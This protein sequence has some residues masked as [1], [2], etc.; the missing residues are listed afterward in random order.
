MD[1]GTNMYSPGPPQRVWVSM[2]HLTI[3]CVPTHQ[4]CIVALELGHYVLTVLTLTEGTCRL[5]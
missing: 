1:T 5:D 3:S 4:K 2:P